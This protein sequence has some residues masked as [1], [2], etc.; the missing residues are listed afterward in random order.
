MMKKLL[1]FMLVLGMAS[2]A[3]AT[4]QIS[5]NDINNPDDPL[6]LT[7]GSHTLDIWTDADIK[8]GIGEV[9]YALAGLSDLGIAGGTLTN[10]EWWG[11]FI[12]DDAAGSGIAVPSGDNG[13]FGGMFTSST[14]QT[15]P[16]GSRIFDGINLT[17]D[18]QITTLT[19]YEINGDTGELIR[20]MDTVN[21]VPEPATIALLGLGGLLL[22]RRK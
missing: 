16:A 17:Y 21:L 7:E 1:I 9:F 18:G 8:T 12:Y 13:V 20:T 15:I 22:R 14:T 5:V 19:L 6:S 10:S 4:L 11:C 3:S 2:L